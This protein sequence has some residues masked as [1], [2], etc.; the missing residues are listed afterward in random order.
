MTEKEE[1]YKPVYDEDGKITSIKYGTYYIQEITSIE[2][3]IQL[4]NEQKD[5]IRMWRKLSSK[6]K[7]LLE[8]NTKPTANHGGEDVYL[9][10]GENKR[11]RYEKTFICNKCGY[12]SSYFLDCRLMME[13]NQYQKAKWLGLVKE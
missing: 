3:V 8:E 11:C 2:E 13:D 4:L 7:K 9:S 6:L 10:I 5:T 12:F 1:Y